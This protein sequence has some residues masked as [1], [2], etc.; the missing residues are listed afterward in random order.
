MDWIKRTLLASLLTSL[1]GIRMGLWLLLTMLRRPVQVA[2]LLVTAGGLFGGMIIMPAILY[3]GGGE[4]GQ[5]FPLVMY[6]AFI[7][8]GFVM[9]I[10][11]G[12]LSVF[13]D[14]LL[15]KLQPED[16]DVIYY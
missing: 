5:E 12:L 11:G 13:Y 15:F 6:A 8:L 1:Y 3:F 10:G 14:K 7:G 9:F 4:R 16:R 2:S